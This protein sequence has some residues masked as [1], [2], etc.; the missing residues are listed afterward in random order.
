MQVLKVRIKFSPKLFEV[1]I[2]LNGTYQV[3]PF[4]TRILFIGEV[5][6]QIKGILSE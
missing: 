4:L 2:D 6:I 1:Y 3:P 5:S